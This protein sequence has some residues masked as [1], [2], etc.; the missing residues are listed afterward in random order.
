MH[1]FLNGT[2]DIFNILF[3][4]TIPVTQ[5]PG[6]L[7]G[8]IAFLVSWKFFGKL[9]RENF[10]VLLAA[11]LAYG[12]L[13]SAFSA[14]PA[15]GYTAMVG[16]LSHWLLPFLLGYLASDLSAARKAFFG[17][18]GIFLVI[19]VFSVL[20]YFGLFFK[21]IAPGFLL[22]SPDGMLLKGFKSHI[23]LAAL[24]LMF[25]FLSLGQV[26]FNDGLSRTSKRIYF[27]LIFFFLAALFL[28]G[29]RGY[30]IAAV[31][32]YSLLGAVLVLKT[33]KAHLARAAGSAAALAGLISL[34][35]FATPMLQGR[36]ERTN[37]QE[38]NV[39]QRLIIYRVAMDEIK[40][41]PAFGFGPGQ[42]IRQTSFFNSVPENQKG[43]ATFP[44][45]H[46]FYL[47]LA[48]DFG[49]AGFALFCLMG[50]SLFTKVWKAFS[51]STGFL[52][53]AAFGV[54]WG[55]VGIFAG[56][57][58]DTFLRGPRIAMDLFWLT[59]IV[60]GARLSRNSA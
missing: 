11:F 35:Y 15:V 27:A 51:E 4:L 9:K 52:K 18:F 1:A 43:V 8:G 44:H 42:G 16:Y 21:Q 20:A 31:V 59:G 22:V 37:M 19:A 2:I 12:F 30:Y 46:S 54:F 49:L 14:E 41:R 34:L 5:I 3:G 50:V 28:T 29:S 13:R 47:N 23:G 32:S 38:N 45:L 53:A 39:A 17:Y 57:C 48:A 55:M 40:A 60:L 25:S 33:G 36:I 6:Y 26:V 7:F 58:F 56:D 24:C 10:F